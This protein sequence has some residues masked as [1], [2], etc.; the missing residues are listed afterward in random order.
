[1]GTESHWCEDALED[2]EGTKRRCVDAA[3][4]NAR[5]LRRNKGRWQSGPSAFDVLAEKRH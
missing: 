2:E 5:A 1:M 3:L 4:R